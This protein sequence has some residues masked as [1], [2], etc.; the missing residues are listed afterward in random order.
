MVR[1]LRRA[2]TVLRYGLKESVEGEEVR[3]TLVAEGSPAMGSAWQAV[4]AKFPVGARVQLNTRGPVM[5]VE[6]HNEQGNRIECMWFAGKK[7]Q[8]DRFPPETLKLMPEDAPCET[9]VLSYN[10]DPDRIPF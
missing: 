5:T 7:L 6:D 2:W 10:E 8:R 4:T 1:T 3:V 9:M